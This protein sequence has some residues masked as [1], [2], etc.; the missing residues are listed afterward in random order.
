MFLNEEFLKIWE[1]L[2]VLNEDWSDSPRLKDKV[3]SAFIRTNDK[4]EFLKNLPLDYKNGKYGKPSESGLTRISESLKVIN[5]DTGRNFQILQE[6]GWLALNDFPEALAEEK[7]CYIIRNKYTGQAYVGK[8][9]SFKSRITAHLRSYEKDSAALHEAIKNHESDFVWGVLSIEE[10]SANRD[11][12]EARY[13]GRNEFKESEPSLNTL[14]NLF[15]YNLVPG[16]KGGS[17]SS[18]ELEQQIKIIWRLYTE[19]VLNYSGIGRDFKIDHKSVINIDAKKYAWVV[20]LAKHLKNKKPEVMTILQSVIPEQDKTKIDQF[21]TDINNNTT[22][23][24]VSDKDEREQAKKTSLASN[25]LYMKILRGWIYDNN[26]IL[27]DGTRENP[28]GEKLVEIN[29]LFSRETDAPYWTRGEADWPSIIFTGVP[30]GRI[31]AGRLRRYLGSNCEKLKNKSNYE[32]LIKICLD[33][34]LKH[35]K[36]YNIEYPSTVEELRLAEYAGELMNEFLRVTDVFKSARTI[37]VASASKLPGKWPKEEE[38]EKILGVKV[39]LQNQL[40]KA[41]E[42]E[43]NTDWGLT[44]IKGTA[45]NHIEYSSDPKV[46]YKFNSK[47]NYIF[48]E[49]ITRLAQ[50]EQDN[51]EK[52]G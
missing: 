31:I 21:I 22:I 29:K 36:K 5:L 49:A 52:A 6:F 9:T 37:M 10:L 32:S 25:D 30:S 3:L 24:P 40:N 15:D 19:E 33:L 38:L 34:I 14:Y 47:L 27:K 35:C 46:L 41:I 12:Q 7:G 1:E 16:G 8:A 11:N 44:A 51:I 13:I 23:H 4:Q 43:K 26:F 2:S 45:S 48:S 39:N 28:L 17:G 18:L 42:A 20:D 50:A